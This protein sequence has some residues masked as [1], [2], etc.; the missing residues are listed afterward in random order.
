MSLDLLRRRLEKQ[1][2]EHCLVTSLKTV[3]KLQT[4]PCFFISRL[5]TMN[6]PRRSTQEKEGFRD[7]GSDLDAKPAS[8]SRRVGN[9]QA[10]ALLSAVVDFRPAGNILSILLIL[11][12]NLFPVFF[13]SFLSPKP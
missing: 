8:A 13:I 6:A 10:M 11:S 5:S 9:A 2:P 3:L 4:D 7:Q 1:N 12:K